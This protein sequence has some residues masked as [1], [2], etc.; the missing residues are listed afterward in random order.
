MILAKDHVQC[1]AFV[2]AV[3]IFGFYNQRIDTLAL[4]THIVF[5]LSCAD[6]YCQVILKC[7]LSFTKNVFSPFLRYSHLHSKIRT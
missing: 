5:V 3:L 1:R 2:L 7:G 4:Y 6:K